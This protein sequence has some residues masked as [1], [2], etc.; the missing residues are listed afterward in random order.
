M[1]RLNQ[2]NSIQEMAAGDMQ[3]AELIRLKKF[4]QVQ[5]FLRCQ[6]RSKMDQL[7]TY[8]SPY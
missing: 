4:L 7:K 5:I 6:L 1:E 8:Y 3:D 2:T